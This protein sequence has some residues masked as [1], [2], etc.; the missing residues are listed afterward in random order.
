MLVGFFEGSNGR[1]CK[2]ESS[3]CRGVLTRGDG[4][5]REGSSLFYDDIQTPASDL[6]SART[7][8]KDKKEGAIIQELAIGHRSVVTTP[9][10][11]SETKPIFG[12]FA[13]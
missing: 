6:P 5:L 1:M 11:Y 7:K 9:K 2:G 4:E 3:A 8:V 12:F 13:F 10:T